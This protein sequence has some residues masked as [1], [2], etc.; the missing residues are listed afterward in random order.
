MKWN[1]YEQNKSADFF[2]PEF[3]FGEKEKFDIVIGN[4]PY[5]AKLSQ[6][7]IEE[8]KK[9][10]LLKTTET[11]ILFIEKGYNLLKSKGVK[12]YIIPKSFTFASNYS[13]CRDYL[14]NNIKLIVDCGKAFENVKLETV[15]VLS[16][17]GSIL[18]NYSSI[19]YDTE[20]FFKNEI[21]IKKEVSSKFGFYLNNVKEEEINIAIKILNSSVYLKDIATNTRGETLQKYISNTGKYKI[22]GGKEI[23]RYKIRGVKGYIDEKFIKSEKSKIKDNSLLTQNIIAHITKPIEHI[24]IICCIPKNLNY[25]ILDTINQ[26]I[27]YNK[28]YKKEFLWAILNSKLI[29]WYTY[30]F[31]FAKAIRTMHFDN[32]VTNRLPIPKLSTEK[33][34]PFETLVDYIIYLKENAEKYQNT[35]LFSADKLFER[36]I[37]FMVY[38]LYFEN[39]MKADG[40]YINDEVAP[41]LFSVSPLKGETK[42]QDIGQEKEHKNEAKKSPHYQGGDLEGGLEQQIRTVYNAFKNNKLIMKA[43]TFCNVEEVKIIEESIKTNSNEVD[44][45]IDKNED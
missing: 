21:I 45:E 7:N 20:K 8:I 5:G 35:D 9:N 17:K 2:D 10:Y 15:I 4:P 13:N 18:N 36:V 1:P 41:I 34:K 28:N 23:D 27:I 30:I 24:K 14:K 3:M 31:I 40:T 11:A 39:E 37:D 16:L 19:T 32:S 26:I 6:C 43:L 38:G 25:V 22:I 12:S 33:Q 42:V 29:N 44:M